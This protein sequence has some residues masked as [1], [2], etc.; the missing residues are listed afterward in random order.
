M[1]KISIEGYKMVCDMGIKHQVKQKSGV[2]AFI[3][4]ELSYD[5]VDSYMEEDMMPEL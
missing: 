4:E 1:E 2:V 5:I 3:K